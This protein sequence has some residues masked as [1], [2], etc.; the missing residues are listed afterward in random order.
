MSDVRRTRTVAA[1]T[2]AV[3]D[4][5]ADFGALATW[6]DG[7]DHCC[8]LNG[9]RHR[10]P[11]G[12]T[13][14]IQIGRDVFLETVLEF[15]PRRALA[16]EITGLPRGFSVVNRWNL[17]P[18]SGTTTVSLTGVSLT[19]VSP[20]RVS[21]TSTVRVSSAL[22]RPVGERALAAM[23]GRRSDSLLNSLATAVEGKP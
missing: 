17:E 10:Q 11:I 23:M 5:L 19:G 12:W 7:I 13:R 2:A 16:Y 6:A 22:L 20:T 1:E 15:E 21:L 4:L 14:R 9:E 18:G 3:W 8:L